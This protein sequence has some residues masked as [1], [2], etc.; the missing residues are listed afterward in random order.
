MPG[1][2]LADDRTRPAAFDLVLTGGGGGAGTRRAVAP[3]LFCHFDV[4]LTLFKGLVGS[5]K[6]ELSGTSD[7]GAA[8]RAETRDACCVLT[9]P[10]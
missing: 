7:G 5:R 10:T 3:F 9:C 4:V 6:S 2:V 1:M 8:A